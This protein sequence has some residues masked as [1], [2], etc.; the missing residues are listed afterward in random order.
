MSFQREWFN[1]FVEINE[2]VCLGDNS[3]C[4]VKGRDNIHIQK[5]IN[6]KWIDGRIND[7]LYVPNLRKNLFSTGVVTQKG[8]DLRLLRTMYLSICKEI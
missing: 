8:F 3:T 1:D 7:V 2:S 6:G 4:Q 5:Y